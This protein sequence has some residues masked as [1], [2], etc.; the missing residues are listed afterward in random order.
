MGQTGLKT[1]QVRRWGTTY[2]GKGIGGPTISSA[3]QKDLT[4]QKGVDPPRDPKDHMAGKSLS[5]QGHDVIST[6]DVIS[7]RDPV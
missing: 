3:N 7:T 1:G 2:I 4:G 5:T 6:Y